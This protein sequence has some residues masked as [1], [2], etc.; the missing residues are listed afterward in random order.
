VLADSGV[1]AAL[2]SRLGR[3][4]DSIEVEVEVDADAARGMRW[5]AGIEAAAYFV[6]REGIT[7]A[8]KHAPGA[9]VRVTLDGSADQLVVEVRDDGPG[10]GDIL[11]GT[12]L[13]GIR[14]RVDSWGGTFEVRATAPHG[15]I[16]RACLPVGGTR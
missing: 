10:I 13:A 14:D 11:N 7:N 2:D 8:L 3:L 9:R 16:V 15:T 5:A 6:A 12:D 1:V 4:P